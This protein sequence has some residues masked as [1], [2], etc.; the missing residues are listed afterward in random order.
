M[1]QVILCKRATNYRALWREMTYKDKAS[2]GSSPPCTPCCNMY[3]SM[4]DASIANTSTLIKFEVTVESL[5][6]RHAVSHSTLQRAATY[7]NTLQH[8]GAY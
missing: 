1:L 8:T 4:A 3:D 2:C 6:D 7:C 5:D